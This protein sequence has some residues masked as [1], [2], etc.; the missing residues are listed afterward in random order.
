[1]L[2][3]LSFSLMYLFSF[4]IIHSEWGYIS[5]FSDRHSS[6]NKKRAPLIILVGPFFF[7]SLPLLRFNPMDL[8][9]FSSIFPSFTLLIQNV[10]NHIQR[11]LLYY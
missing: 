6:S 9:C 1:M 11:R 2:A 4:L 7:S 5:P 3:Q 10:I 8:I